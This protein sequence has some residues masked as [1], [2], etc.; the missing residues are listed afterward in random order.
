MAGERWHV[1]AR[2]GARLCCLDHNGRGQA[3][4][5]LHGLAGY[6]G[7]WHE[8]A[9]WLSETFRVVAV[10]QRGHGRSERAPASVSPDAFVADVEL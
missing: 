8:T 1:E 3:V 5:L 4:V 2:E 10:E 7:E 9:S 6:A